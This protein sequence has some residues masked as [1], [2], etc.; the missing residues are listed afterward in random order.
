V[1]TLLS[2]EW[3]AP[4]LMSEIIGRSRFVFASSLYA[5]ITA[6]SYG[7]PGARVPVYSDRKFEL[8]DEFEGIVH[9]DEQKEALARLINRGRRIEPR[10]FEYADCLERHWDHVRDVVVQPPLEPCN[11]SRKLMLSESCSSGLRHAFLSWQSLYPSGL[12]PTK[13]PLGPGPALAHFEGLE[14]VSLGLE[15]GGFWEAEFALGEGQGE[16]FLNL[17]LF[18]VAGHGQFADQEVAGAFEHLLFAK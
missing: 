9:I 16:E 14:S 18:A 17:G 13:F 4:K 1:R 3:L 5:C 2:R 11:P 7:V 6:L 8:L 15:F 12:K 10:V